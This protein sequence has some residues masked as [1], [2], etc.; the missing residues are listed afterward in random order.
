[1]A[2][3]GTISELTG[4]DAAGALAEAMTW[5]NHQTLGYHH[6]AYQAML[7]PI[8]ADRLTCLAT[9]G[10]GG[11]LT[12]IFPYRTK[13][14]SLGAVINALPFFG[15]NGL[16]LKKPGQGSPVVESLLAA[17]R[18]RARA[19]EVF[20][21]TLYAPFGLDTSAWAQIL[22]TDRSL[23]KFTQVMFLGPAAPQWSVKRRGDIK[24]ARA[25]GFS[26]RQATLADEAKIFEIYDENCR[27]AGIPAKP[28]AFVAGTL[29]ISIDLAESSPMQWL[30]ATLDNEVAAALLYGR[31]PLTGSYILPC[32]TAAVR[33]DQPNALLMDHAIQES[34]TRGVRFWNFESSPVW[35]DPVFKF[36]GR[37]GSRAVP[38]EMFFLYGGR[39]AHPDPSQI[40][41]VRQEAPY[42]FAAPS[43]RVTGTWPE[44]IAPPREAYADFA[45][46]SPSASSTRS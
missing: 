7:T 20:S 13:T 32:A 42:Y 29:R 4:P 25:R 38:Y 6:P 39:G 36:K 43:G 45:A 22:A 12:G 44:D 23:M 30:V 34:L 35:D 21:A 3:P 40:A 2:E 18:V 41:T 10:V 15:A 28:R 16:V 27:S 33:A 46:I 19:R 1:M 8:L 11:A 26:V 5:S 14:T 31:G 37:W 24:R 17:F 9:H